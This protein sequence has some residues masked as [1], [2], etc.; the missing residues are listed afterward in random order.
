MPTM[1]PA[2]AVATPMPIILRAPATIPLEQLL[3]GPCGIAATG[4]PDRRNTAS[5]GRWVTM[6]NSISAVAQ[7]ADRPGDS[8]STIRFQTRTTMG[9]RK[10]SPDFTV[11]P[12]PAAEMIGAFGSSSSS[13][14]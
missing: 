7:K 4:G 12:A 9:S 2:V 8:R 1:M 10:C 11:G 13:S 5:S 6:M 14:G 3:Q